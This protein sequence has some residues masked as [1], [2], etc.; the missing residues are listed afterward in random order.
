MTVYHII[1]LVTGVLG[2][3]IPFILHN[4]WTLNAVQASAWSSL[5][6]ALFF[7]VFNDSFPQAYSTV[8]PA[9]FF[10]ASFIG[11]A[12]KTILPK[13]WQVGLA[14][15]IFSLI[16]MNTSFFFEGYGGALGTTACIAVVLV[17]GMRQV[18]KI[19]PSKAD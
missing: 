18:F 17:F 15:F 6:V 14:G 7:Y 12:T 1:I 9:V 10:G 11:M 8:I 2:A 13:L 5:I 16:Y 19:K 3:I 4:S